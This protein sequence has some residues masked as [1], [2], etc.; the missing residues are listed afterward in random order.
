MFA[1]HEPNSNQFG[2][3][4]RDLLIGACIRSNVGSAPI[5]HAYEECIENLRASNLTRDA[6]D[7]CVQS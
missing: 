6:F 1:S 2:E 7:G 3:D 4:A 5:V